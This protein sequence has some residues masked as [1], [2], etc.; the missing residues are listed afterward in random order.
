MLRAIEARYRLIQFDHRGHGMSQRDLPETYAS[1]DRLFRTL[2]LS[3]L[4]SWQTL[5]SDA[6][7]YRVGD[8]WN[9]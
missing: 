6:G 5:R 8:D 2:R 1:E 4:E 9:R 7:A 3:A